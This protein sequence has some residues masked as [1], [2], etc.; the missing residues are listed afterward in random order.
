MK[1]TLLIIILLMALSPSI[2]A[3]ADIVSGNAKTYAGD[4]LTIY[5]IDD[6]ITRHETPVATAAVDAD[7]NFTFSVPVSNITQAYIDLAV[8]KCMIYLQPGKSQRIILPE[9]QKIEPQ[10]ALNPFFKKYEFYPKLID[11][12]PDDLNTLIPR[13]DQNYGNALNRIV[14]A[15]FG[16]SKVVVDSVESII[17]A[18]YPKDNP[19]FSNYMKYRFA[20]LDH[21]AYHR[22]RDIIISEYFTGKE[23]LYRNPAYCELFDEMYQ[24]IFSNFKHHFTNNADK[25]QA[26]EDKS[27]NALKRSIAAEPKVGSAQLADYMIL[28]GLKDSYYADTIHKEN[29]IA[30]ADSVASYCGNRDFRTIAYALSTDFT[31]LLCGHAAPKLDLSDING[32]HKSLYDFAGKFAYVMFFNPDSYTAL[33]DLELI[34]GIR[35]DFSPGIL[36]IVVVFVSNSRDE[37]KEFVESDPELELPIYWYNGNK[38]MLRKY[39]VRAYPTYYLISP[40]SL[41]NMAPAPSP[42]ENFQPKFDAAYRTWRNDR[43]RKQYQNTPGL[44]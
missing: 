18:R 16:V 30:I 9:K 31:T 13:F 27:Y 34:K 15:K 2:L 36:D 1:R 38:E 5:V 26:I 42:T 41:I 4:T 40:E 21:I 17:S 44:K 8:F 11:P 24:N 43:A 35:E 14:N 32:E 10:D 29:L 12:A 6:Y 33:S 23:V 25:S 20:M 3:Q 28:K 7:G 22:N 19:Y 37:Y 39:N